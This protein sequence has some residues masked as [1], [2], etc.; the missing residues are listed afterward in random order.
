VPANNSANVG[1][2]VVLAAPEGESASEGNLFSTVGLG[3]SFVNFGRAQLGVT[4]SA[5]FGS[6][7]TTVSGGGLFL[8]FPVI[9]DRASIDISSGASFLTQ[10]DGTSTSPYLSGSLRYSL[11]KGRRFYLVGDGRV[12]HDRVWTGIGL[13]VGRR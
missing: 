4:A 2:S 8:N 11:M 12:S 10:S 3:R 13:S 6:D 7:R 5:G 9:P 1:T